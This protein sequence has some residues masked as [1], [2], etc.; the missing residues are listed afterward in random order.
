VELRI[1]FRVEEVGR[2]EVALEHL[3]GDR[4]AGD[5]DRAFELR[6]LAAGQ[7]GL[8]GLEGAAERGEAVVD[9]GEADRR[10]DRVHGVSPGRDLLLGLRGHLGSFLLSC[11]SK[12]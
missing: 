8:V 10:V 5:P 3:L 7:G 12:H 4:D 9:D 11:W 6:S 1:L 2:E